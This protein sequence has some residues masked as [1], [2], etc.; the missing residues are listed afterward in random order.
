MQAAIT[1]KLR[2]HVLLACKMLLL[3]ISLLAQGPQRMAYQLV[4]HDNS[5]ALVRNQTVTLRISILQG[6]VN[7]IPV[8]SE[9]HAAGSN[10]NGLVNIS[11][12]GGSVLSGSY[13]SINWSSGVFFLKTE[14]RSEERR[15]GKE[16]RSRWSPY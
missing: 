13:N 15:V 2:I 7:G 1:S 6:G 5:N 4:V 14:T 12:G 3:Q 9:V 8:Y 16:C 11:I 10:A